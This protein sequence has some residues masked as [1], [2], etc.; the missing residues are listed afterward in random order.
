MKMNFQE[1]GWGVM[2]C[3]N[4]AQNR[5]GWRAPVNALMNHRIP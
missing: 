3:I 5:D 1:V 2:D 4:L